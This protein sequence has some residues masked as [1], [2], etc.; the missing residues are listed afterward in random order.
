[1]LT[2]KRRQTTKRQSN[3]RISVDHSHWQK[4]QRDR[5]R[6]A[7]VCAVEAA[8][9]AALGALYGGE[10]VT[11]QSLAESNRKIYRELEDQRS[12]TKEWGGGGGGMVCTYT[13]GGG[14]TVGY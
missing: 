13:V 5:A 11:A 6:L 7:V 2:F 4:Q 1:V 8:I 9:I 3:D 14:Y 12:I 10:H